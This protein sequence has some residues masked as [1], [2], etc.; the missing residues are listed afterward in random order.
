MAKIRKS[1]IRQSE[2]RKPKIKKTKNKKTLELINKDGSLKD[3]ISIK[4][5]NKPAFFVRI[6]KKGLRQM[7][8]LGF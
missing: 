5:Y 4:K 8:K 6:K 3:V 7:N 1:K 2:I